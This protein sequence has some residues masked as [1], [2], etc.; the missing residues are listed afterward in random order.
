MANEQEI[1][2][3]EPDE[4]RDIYHEPD[5]R[6]LIRTKDVYQTEL[7]NGVEGYSETMLAIVANF[8]NAGKPEGFNVQ[9]M[10]ASRS[11]ARWRCACSRWSTTPLPTRCS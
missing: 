9:S 10:V 5:D 4:G 3:D 6:A 8:K 11:A 7:D 1:T 2:F